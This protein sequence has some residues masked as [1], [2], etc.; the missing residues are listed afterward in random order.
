MTLQ[1][2][3]ADTPELLSPTGRPDEASLNWQFFSGNRHMK[4]VS[5]S[6]S[7]TCTFSSVPTLPRDWVVMHALPKELKQWNASALYVLGNRS[8]VH[9]IPSEGYSNCTFIPVDVSFVN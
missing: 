6:S 2:D 8:S 1:A 9:G 4:K 5:S 3:T 7:L